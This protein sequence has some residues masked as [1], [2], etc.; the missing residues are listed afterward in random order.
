MAVSGSP[1]VVRADSGRSQDGVT[2]EGI[3]NPYNF[4]SSS[5]PLKG[6]QLYQ[7]AMSAIKSPT[8]ATASTTPSPSDVPSKSN[9]PPVA[10]PVQFQPGPAPAAAPPANTPPP[11]TPPPVTPP[12]ANVHQFASNTPPPPASSPPAHIRNDSGWLSAEDEKARLRY[13]DAKRAVEQHT[14]FQDDDYGAGSSSYDH[15]GPSGYAGGSSSQSAGGYYSGY[16]S[17]PPNASIRNDTSGYMSP[18]PGNPPSWNTS[19]PAP[20]PVVVDP[21]RQHA[22]F[23]PPPMAPK[24]LSAY[25]SA[26]AP[27]PLNLSSTPTPPPP[28]SEP[29]PFSPSLGYTHATD[30]P[31][32]E[33]MRLAFAARDQA[34]APS[35]ANGDLPPPDYGGPPPGNPPSVNG[36]DS[37]PPI[38]GGGMYSSQPLTAAEEK[39]RLKAQWAAED[40]TGSPIAAGSSSEAGAGSSIYSR[41]P[42]EPPLYVEGTRNLTAAEEKARLQALYAAERPISTVPPAPPPRVK[43]PPLSTT[44]M[45]AIS[46]RPPPSSYISSSSISSD[47]DY[48]RRDPSI[49]QGK[50]RAHL[51]HMQGNVIN[52]SPIVSSSPS[53]MN[54][55]DGSAVA[56]VPPIPPPLAPRPPKEYIERTKEEDLKIR[57]MTGDTSHFHSFTLDG[58]AENKPPWLGTGSFLGNDDFSLG[59]RPFSPIDLSLGDVLRNNNASP[60]PTNGANRTSLYR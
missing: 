60:Q 51:Q 15:G 44:P 27:P 20:P 7:S 11:F 35:P 28:S 2:S 50:Q 18:P 33:K 30:I 53:A 6:A 16:T 5:S 25:Q 31:E 37:P 58:D 14:A 48:L 59:L 12:L 46:E 39:A 3:V 57:R 52:Q 26:I 45:S 4:S 43:S 21:P 41:P 9:S 38:D 10:T 32:K 47:S 13:L 49:T 17:P 40:T 1:S 36:Y 42:P 24:H 55:T 22:T 54:A 56:G 23:S 29:P 34:A 8:T 19:S